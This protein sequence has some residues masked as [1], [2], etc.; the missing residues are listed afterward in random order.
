MTDFIEFFK[1]FGFP[2]GLLVVVL[3]AI[4]LA[5][6]TIARTLS[7]WGKPLVE[8]LVRRFIQHLDKTDESM[9]TQAK[10]SERQ[11]EANERTAE[12]QQLQLRYLRRNG[13]AISHGADALDVITPPDSPAKPHIHKMR[14]ELKDGE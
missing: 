9:A 8:H 1:T 14:G 5:G 4:W 10:A 3:S 6:R 7:A 13:K 2:A 12:S 11:A